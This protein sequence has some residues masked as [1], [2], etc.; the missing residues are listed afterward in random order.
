MGSL[1]FGCERRM[2]ALAET[3]KVA[4][5]ESEM[6]ISGELENVVNVDS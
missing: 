1:A 4:E 3:R 5:H 6:W 2:A